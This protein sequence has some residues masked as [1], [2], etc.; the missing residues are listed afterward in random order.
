MH[1]FAITKE[2]KQKYGKSKLRHPHFQP[3]ESF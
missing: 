2:K 3:K 1:A